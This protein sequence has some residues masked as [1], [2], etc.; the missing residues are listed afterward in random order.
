ME[1]WQIKHT[2]VMRD[3]LHYLNAK[4]ENYI[5]KGGSSL[6]ECYGMR[7]FS[8]DLDFD[9]RDRQRMAQIVDD[10][11]KERGYKFRTAKNT[12]SVQRYMINYGDDSHPLKV[13]TSFRRTMIPQQITEKRNGIVVYDIDELLS[14]KTTAYSQ[15]DKIRDMYD[16]SFIIN[17][18]G[19]NLQIRSISLAANAI[20]Q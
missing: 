3:F 9:S 7:R 19:N 8:A 17:K 10:F 2:D 13:E 1:S 15:R 14:Q 20:A 12:P 18:Y 6:I 5:L 4:T 16:I 11:C